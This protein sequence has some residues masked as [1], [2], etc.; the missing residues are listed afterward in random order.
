MWLHV[1][2]NRANICRVKRTCCSGE[3]WQAAVA[4]WCFALGQLGC[5]GLVRCGS[6]GCPGRAFT[7]DFSEATLSG[8]QSQ[9][10]PSL[11]EVPSWNPAAIHS[12]PYRGAV[13]PAPPR[14]GG[15]RA[16]MPVGSLALPGY[17]LFCA[18]QPDAS[19]PLNQA[20]ASDRAVRRARER[21]LAFL[22]LGVHCSTAYGFS[23]IR[24][25]NSHPTRQHKKGVELRAKFT[26][27]IVTAGHDHHS[28]LFRT[29]TVQALLMLVE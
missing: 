26:P 7:Q 23:F 15:K 8:S 20:S 4:R 11:L 1:E 21:T 25:S 12:R 29:S 17:V 22:S 13:P 3:T 14:R 5:R 2:M 28:L 24:R 9:V 18:P 6:V 19:Q 27:C 10:Q 16:R